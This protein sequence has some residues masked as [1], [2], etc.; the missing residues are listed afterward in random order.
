MYLVLQI[1]IDRR[2][3]SDFPRKFWVHKWDQF[4]FL[5]KRIGGEERKCILKSLDFKPIRPKDITS[6]VE[7][8]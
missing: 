3:P 6:V 4:S 8:E 2:K 1:M 5:L 7:W